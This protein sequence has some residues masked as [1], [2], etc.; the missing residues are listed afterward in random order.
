MKKVLTLVLTLVL[1]MSLCTAMAEENPYEGKK[2]A[3]VTATESFEFFIKSQQGMRDTLD[4]AGIEWTL[5]N[6]DLDMDR[7]IEYLTQ[8]MAM[9]YD[10]VICSFYDN[11]VANNV[12]EELNAAGII[13][14]TWEAAPSVPE[15]AKTTVLSNDYMA[16]YELGIRM[17]ED[18][19]GE[20]DIFSYANRNITS[21]RLRLEGLE[22]AL[23]EYPN[24]K[25][26]TNLEDPASEND[27]TSAQALI[28]SVLQLYPDVKGFF[29]A[30]ES[31][32]LVAAPLFQD[33]GKEIIV[34]TVDCTE[35]ILNY[36]QAGVVTYCVDQNA[37]QIG[38]TTAESALALL[39]G[40]TVEQTQYV[41]IAVVDSSNYAEY[42][43]K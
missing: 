10:A 42:L 2:I 5:Y 40:E 26:V 37:Y 36:M 23:K 22:A 39:R 16:G 12:L 35:M 14:V 33:L 32:T 19:G 31:N 21:A 3:I 8:C 4:A 34:A 1:T 29:S 20:G 7:Q 18:M 41:D 24:V 17:C 30:G 27:T 43:E 9:E 25:L 15:L 11:S 28:Q 13:V 38:V 6:W